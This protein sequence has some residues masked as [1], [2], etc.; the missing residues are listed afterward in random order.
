MRLKI[1]LRKLVEYQALEEDVARWV[2]LNPNYIVKS[3]EHETFVNSKSGDQELLLFV[4][5]HEA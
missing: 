2:D 1:F 3:S 5:Y 4:W